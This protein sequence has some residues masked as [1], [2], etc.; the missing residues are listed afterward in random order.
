MQL[1]TPA[2]LW[3]TDYGRIFLAKM[4][5]VIGLMGLAAFNRRRLTPML[6]LKAAGSRHLLRSIA[7]EIGLA[8]VILALVAAWRFTPPPVLS[9]GLRPSP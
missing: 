4:V 6:E 1:E 8:V 7:G 5:A 3:T 9:S 2:A